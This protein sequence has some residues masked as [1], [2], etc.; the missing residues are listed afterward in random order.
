M[1]ETKPAEDGALTSKVAK[2]E[3]RV[4]RFEGS[5]DRDQP[6]TRA[7]SRSSGPHAERRERIRA[8]T[9]GQGCYVCGKLGH[10]A[11]D[12]TETVDWEGQPIRRAGNAATGKDAGSPS[13]ANPKSA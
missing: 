4:S 1:P 13:P 12:C 5:R 2:L 9:D 10:Y 8:A 11:S 6:P 3:Q 7:R